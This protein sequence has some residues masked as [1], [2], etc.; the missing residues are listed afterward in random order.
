M[1]EFKTFLSESSLSRLYQKVKDY[2]AGAITAFRGSF[3]KAEN[4]DRNKKLLAFLLFHDYSVTKVKGSYIE[5]YGSEN[6]KE[7]G[8]ESFFVVDH[9]K[10]GKLKKDLEDLG[11]L[12]DQDSILWVESGKPGILIGTSKRE[13]SF[14]GYKKTLVVGKPNFGTA[15]GAFFSRVGGRK[16][17]F[18]SVE[19]AQKPDTINGLRALKIITEELLNN[20]A[21]KCK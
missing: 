19:D 15:A 13:D 5:N 11:H 18:E 2:D 6:E 16:F 3:T 21:F 20:I 4:K 17:S 14:P 1:K 7:V 10:T 12:Y 8:E 9:N